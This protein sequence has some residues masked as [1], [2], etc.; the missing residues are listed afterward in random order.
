MSNPFTQIYTADLFDPLFE[1]DVV[2]ATYIR[3]KSAAGGMFP[4]PAPIAR[5]TDTV[6]VDKLVKAGRVILFGPDHFLMPEVTAEREARVRGGLVA[7]GQA[8]RGPD[9]RFVPAQPVEQPVQPV[10][11]PPPAMQLNSEHALE[12]ST[13]SRARNRAASSLADD[14]PYQQRKRRY[15]R[16]ETN[17]VHLTETERE[18]FGLPADRGEEVEEL[19]W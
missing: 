6:V 14:A 10:P 16:A 15:P 12:T 7:S 11:S 19:P 5:S 3:M 8:M 9:G 13:N 1:D 4:S 18:L 2:L 17:E